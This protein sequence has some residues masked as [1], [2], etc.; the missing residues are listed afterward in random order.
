Y[1]S[2]RVGEQAAQRGVH[3]QGL[4][5]GKA[6][7]MDDLQGELIQPDRGHAAEAR[8]ARCHAGHVDPARL[9]GVQ[10]LERVG[11]LASARSSLRRA[12]AERALGLSRIRMRLSWAIQIDLVSSIPAPTSA[13]T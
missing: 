2:E 4:G 6:R 3:V 9:A 13:C 10:R 12:L 5:P 8:S 7:A 1:R 11:E